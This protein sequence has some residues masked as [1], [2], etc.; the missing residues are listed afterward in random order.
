MIS[1]VLRLAS[2]MVCDIHKG[3]LACNASW[4]VIFLTNLPVLL[5][6]PAV[7][8]SWAQSREKIAP[9]RAEQILNW[10]QNLRD[11]DVQPDKYTF[12][13]VIHSYAKAGGTEAA[14]KAQELLTKMHKIYQEG[15]VLAKPD[16]IT[17]SKFSESSVLCKA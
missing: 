11:L 3:R 16:T 4:S 5:C 6:V 13:T 8:N 9:V 1:S 17:Y 7:I 12:N 14:A 2:S 15:N 10:M